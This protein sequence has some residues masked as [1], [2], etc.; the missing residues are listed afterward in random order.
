MKKIVFMV[1][2]FMM[3]TIVFNC[4]EP[5]YADNDVYG[6]EV[7]SSV[8]INDLY[9][10]ADTPHILAGDTVFVVGRYLVEAL[11]GKIEW[12]EDTKTVKMTL[13]EK[14][15]EIVIGSIDGEVNGTSLELNKAPFIKE[16][17]TMIPLRFVSENFGCQVSWN[18]STYTVDIKSENEDIPAAYTYTRD[19]T[20]EDLYLLSKIVTVESGDYSLDMAMA[21]AN[22]I[23]NR[24]KDE[25]FPDTIEGVIYQVDEHVQFPPAHKESFETL[26]PKPISIAAAKKALE[27]V[28]SIEDSLYFNNQPF[29]SKSD[30]LINIID[31][32]YFYR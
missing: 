21:I 4:C 1:L 28:N 23:L 18:Q 30:D 9:L 20:D 22:T 16:G 25:S 24:V 7:E 6:Y 8:K 14:V 2:A 12:L 10:Y 31:G 15:I 11:G 5:V 29:V 26:E 19:Y 3:L 27:G 32:E 13:N 17:R